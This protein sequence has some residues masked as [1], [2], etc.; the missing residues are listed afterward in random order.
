[1]TITYT[2]PLLSGPACDRLADLTLRY[3]AWSLT[4]GT[5]GAGAVAYTASH[6]AGVSLTARDPDTLSFLLRIADERMLD[7]E[8]PPPRV[9]PYLIA[10]ERH[11]AAEEQAELAD[12]VREALTGQEAPA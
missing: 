5:D 7:L 12:L 3:T 2:P 8:P 1:M 10:W 11:Q 9:R 6:G 4:Y